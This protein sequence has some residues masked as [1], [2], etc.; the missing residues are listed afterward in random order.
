MVECV[1]VAFS[2]ASSPAVMPLSYCSL[3]SGNFMFYIQE[4]CS[5]LYHLVWWSHSQSS[6]KAPPCFSRLILLLCVRFCSQQPIISED[7]GVG[8]PWGAHTKTRRSGDVWQV[9]ARMWRVQQ[10]LASGWKHCESR[11]LRELCPHAVPRGF[12][13]VY[14]EISSQNHFPSASDKV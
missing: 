7:I 12:P 4:P 3:F 2:V 11:R 6:G 14:G 8:E 10:R 1:C 13:S 5:M 9:C